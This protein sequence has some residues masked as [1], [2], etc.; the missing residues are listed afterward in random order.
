MAFDWQKLIELAPLAL[1]KPGSPQGA[2]FM[3]GYLQS[4]QR[5]EQEQQAAAKQQADEQYRQAQLQNME[6][7]NSRANASLNLQYENADLNRLNAFQGQA[8]KVA[9][10]TVETAD[11]PVAG[12]LGL[13]RQLTGLAGAYGVPPSA[14]AGVVPNLTQ[15][16]SNKDKARAREILDRFDKDRRYDGYRQDTE[17]LEKLENTTI[18]FKNG[19]LKTIKDLRIML[20]EQPMQGGQPLPPMGPQKPLQMLDLGGE[21]RVIDPSTL[22]PGQVFRDVPGPST[23]SPDSEPLVAVIGPD[24][25]P[26]LVPR[27]RAVGQRPASAREQGR[28]VMS[29]DANRLSELDTSLTDLKTLKATLSTPG[30]TGARAKVGAVV[31]NVVTEFTG[32]GE[33]A[34]QRQGTIDR[35]KQVIGKALEGGVLRREDE[36]KY[37]KILPTIQDP[38]AVAASKLSGLEIAIQQRRDN[39]LENLEDANYDIGKFRRGAQTQASGGAIKILSIEEVK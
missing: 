17:G 24:G 27:R 4:K 18:A 31:P 6:A 11:D 36:Y 1:M 32:F 30:A 25:Q 15:A 37:V 26:V 20:G 8:A 29:S 5:M 12:N 7:D 34:K 21:K 23:G 22:Q 39:L 3:Q 14:G 16:I 35:V 2:A 38:P 19:Q 13:A 10:R 9:E 33:S 28:P